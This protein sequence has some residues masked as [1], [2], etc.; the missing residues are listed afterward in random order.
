M[1]QMEIRRFEQ[2]EYHVKEAI[3][4]LCTNL[5]FAGGDIKK[6]MI[7]S[8]R[9]QE[10]K[11]FVTMSLMRALAG[12]GMKVVLVDADIRASRLVSRYGIRVH[13]PEDEKY[14]GLTGYL[15]GVCGID[16]VLAQTDIP[17]A[18]MILAGRT[19]SNSLP[20]LNTPRLK[21]LLDHLAER[22]DV[23]LV[24]AAPVGTIIDAARV[25]SSCDGTLFVIH[26]DETRASELQESIRQIERMGSPICGYVL[27]QFDERKYGGKGRYGKS[28]YRN[29]YHASDDDD[30]EMPA[31]RRTKK[32]A[33]K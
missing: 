11:S 23:V 21:N 31:K 7:T 27:N 5:F 33:D 10:G 4:T 14:L 32:N 18:S 20:L 26:S 30:G 13:M 24:D 8:S 9:P 15:A 22:F 16:K 29:Y 1:V 3:N 2:P 6:I 12:L 25:V 19:V 17:G 28:Y